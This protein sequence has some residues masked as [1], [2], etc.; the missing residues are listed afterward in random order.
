[1]KIKLL[2][3]V[4]LRS[5]PTFRRNIL[6]PSLWYKSKPSER[7]DDSEMSS[8]IRIR[9]EQLAPSVKVVS[10]SVLHS[11]I[12][13]NMPISLATNPYI[14]CCPNALCDS[15]VVHSS[16]CFNFRTIQ[17]IAVNAF[18]LRIKWRSQFC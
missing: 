16:T 15:H 12:T 10:R 8:L 4:I 11:R 6:S 7:R 13:P 3:D 9:M 2:Y 18:R 1:M 17:R 5:L 14:K